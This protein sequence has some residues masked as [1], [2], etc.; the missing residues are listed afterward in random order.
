VC[1]TFRSSSF[2]LLSLTPTLIFMYSP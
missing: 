2:I 1:E